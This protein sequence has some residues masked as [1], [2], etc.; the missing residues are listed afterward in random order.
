LKNTQIALEEMKILENFSKN[1][2][3]ALESSVLM[4][5]S[6]ATASAASKKNK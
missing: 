6:A 3:V 5:S 2:K 4:N 1:S